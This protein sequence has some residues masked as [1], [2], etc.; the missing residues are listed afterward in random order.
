[1]LGPENTVT[2]VPDAF[3][4]GGAATLLVRVLA[5]DV[6]VRVGYGLWRSLHRIP[7]LVAW[8]RAAKAADHD[9]YEEAVHAVPGALGPHPGDAVILQKVIS[10]LR[11]S[12]DWLPG[13]LLAQ[14][15]LWALSEAKN[16]PIEEFPLLSPEQ[17]D[18]DNARLWKDRGAPPK[19]HGSKGRLEDLDRVIRTFYLCEVQRD[20][21]AKRELARVEARPRADVQHDCK[22]ARALLER[23]TLCN[24][25]SAPL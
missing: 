21:I 7:E 14:Y 5:V 20:P 22:R 11:L 13:C 25:I 1:M 4:V 3:R 16:E 2:N 10:S 24:I 23:V 8:L 12:Y 19:R 18:I 15:R 6:D 17:A 9:C